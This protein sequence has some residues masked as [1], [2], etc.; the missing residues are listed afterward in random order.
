MRSLP[1]FEARQTKTGQKAAR[2]RAHQIGQTPQSASSSRDGDGRADGAS[3]S[4]RRVAMRSFLCLSGSMTPFPN[5]SP[6]LKAP[7]SAFGLRRVQDSRTLR[8]LRRS[9]PAWTSN[10]PP[11]SLGQDLENRKAIEPGDPSASSPAIRSRDPH[12][13][14]PVRGGPTSSRRGETTAKSRI[15]DRES[16][17][18]SSC[19]NRSQIDRDLVSVVP[20]GGASPSRNLWRSSAISAAV[21]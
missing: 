7:T 20:T 2:P 5:A 13:R 21:G 15:Q 16:V 17:Q 14:Q 4:W 1:G 18:G 3:T 10:G 6:V 19:L 8:S 12:S 11:V 9:V